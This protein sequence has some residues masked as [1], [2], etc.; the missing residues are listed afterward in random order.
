M[1]TPAH[2][3]LLSI[4]R[5]R[6]GHKDFR[7][8]QEPV[9]RHV[10]EGLDALV[11]MPT[12]AGKSL[13]YQLPALHRPG[14]TIVVSPLIALMKDQVDAL[15]ARG[16][17]ST[18]VNSSIEPDERDRRV[19]QAL[20]GEVRLLYVAPERF[21]IPGFTRK[22][23]TARIALFVIDEAHCLSQWG[24]DFRPSYLRLG[25]A[26]TG[27]GTPPT[28]ALTATATQEVRDDILAVLQL[29]E[30]GVFVTGFDRP[31][32]TLTVRP[33]RNKADKGDVLDEVLRQIARPALI[34]CATRKSVEEV[35]L[36]V[37]RKERIAAYHAGMGSEDRTT[38][39][40]EF[41]AGRW[42]LVAATNA[43]GMGI[44]KE[45][46]RAVLHYDIPRTIEAYYQEIGRAGR[47]GKPAQ[48]VLLYK[49]GD[50]MV[51]EF[52]IDNNHP[53]QWCVQGTWE[54]LRRVGTNPVFRSHKALAEEIGKGATDRMVGSS[55][56]TLERENQMRRL[57]VREGLTELA[58]LPRQPGHDPPNRAGLPM[59]VWTILRRLREQGGHPVETSWSVPLPRQTDEFWDSVGAEKDGKA[60]AQ[61]GLPGIAAPRVLPDTI[62]L[63][64]PSL[65]EELDVDRTRLSATLRTLE[66]RCLIT[67]EPGDRCSGARLLHDNDEIEVDWTELGQRRQRELTRLDQMVEYAEQE[68]CR[69]RAILAYFGEDPD[70]DRCG[71][72]DVCARGGG[73][74]HRP[75]NA[76]LTTTQD[77]IVRKALACVA[78]MGDGQSASMVARVLTGSASEAVLSFHFD[79]LSTYGLCKELTQ[80]QVGAVLRALVRAGCLQETD[81]SRQIRGADRRYRVLSV[82]PL[83]QRV[84][85]QREPEFAMVF[86]D[87]DE[88]PASPPVK[89][90]A[91]SPKESPAGRG[92]DG[93]EDLMTDPADRALFDKLREARAALARAEDVVAFVMGGN[94]LLREIAV[95]RPQTRA[96]MLEM[97][98][99]GERMWDK[100]GEHYL[101]VV[102][103]FLDP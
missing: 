83:G 6:F 41:M 87:L 65:A 29:R 70:W 16:I 76:A 2:Q 49:Q 8:G 61:V 19:A 58:F 78:R 82:T 59:Q 84:M 17:P 7:P 48:I 52:F 68:V 102:K 85:R 89:T 97:P 88:V 62:P 57:P 26:R 67:V 23:A 91:S 63:H 75:R 101:A 77:D 25:E 43:F 80:D 37:G 3:D 46:L 98:G 24:H 39:Q 73:S 4:L 44:D 28:V 42:P 60:P 34:Y 72:C 74:K 36:R 103:A 53:P 1:T 66:E 69:R 21:A 51:Q 90:R 15:T 9:I 56:L 35:V 5:T 30:P 12:G 94:R 22:L 45:D 86:P 54:A 64:L 55:M 18:F 93:G 99:M 79:K 10:A 38:V 32:L 31:N 100:V 13:C 33:C 40:S 92:R 96:E 71:N 27:L 11:I 20:S 81:V 50:R 47:D 14:L 95:S